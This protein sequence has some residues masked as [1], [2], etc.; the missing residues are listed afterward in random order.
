MSWIESHQS[1]A[2][3]PKTTKAAQMLGVEVPTMIGYLHLLWWWA[4]D[5]A[6]DGNLNG[7]TAGQLCDAMCCK[8]DADSCRKDAKSVIRALVTCNPKTGGKGFLE[9]YGRGYIIHDWHDF[10]GKL[11]EKKA[12]DAARKR[13]ERAGRP[14]D[15]PKDVLCDGA[16]TYLPNLPNLPTITRLQALCRDKV[17]GWKASDKDAQ[18]ITLAIDQIGEAE[19]ERLILRLASYQAANNKYKD[20]RRALVNWV[21]RQDKPK[22]AATASDLFEETM[23]A[24][25]EYEDAH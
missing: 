18:V 1:L 8:I 6:P 7:F 14:S 17:P 15:H 4:L 11:I 10:A 22:P 16:G 5:Y 21:N 20:L 13:D 3:H 24:W 2:N 9:R 25:G 23:Q 12:K 19:L